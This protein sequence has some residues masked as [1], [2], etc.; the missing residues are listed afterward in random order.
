M[1]TISQDFS[2]STLYYSTFLT[3]VITHVSSYVDTAVTSVQTSY[4]PYTNSKIF[5][6]NNAEQPM[7]NTNNAAGGPTT[8]SSGLGG[9]ATVTYAQTM[10]VLYL[11][12]H[13]NKANRSNSN[14][15]D[16]FFLYRTAKI[17]LVP[18]VTE[19]NG[20]LACITTS[21]FYP[22]TF[23][24][25]IPGSVLFTGINSH[26]QEYYSSV[27]A[28]TNAT[29]AAEISLS[30]PFVLPLGSIPAEYT[31]LTLPTP[32]VS[33]FINTKRKMARAIPTSTSP[34]PAF[35]SSESEYGYVPNFFI[36]FL[37]QDPNY[38][39]QF[40]QLASCFPGGPSIDPGIKTSGL[41]PGPTLIGNLVSST[42]S[43]AHPSGCFDLNSPLCLTAAKAPSPS[44][45]P[46]AESAPPL[47]PNPPAPIVSPPAPS[48]NSPAAPSPP[49][50]PTYN[51]NSLS[52]EQL[53]NLLSVLQVPSSPPTSSPPPVRAPLQST[54]IQ[55]PP[56]SSPAPL[57]SP[58]PQLIPGSSSTQPPPPSPPTLIS[59]PVPQIIPA[60]S[61]T[62]PPAPNPPAPISSPVP[63]IIPASP[64]TQPPPPTSLQT[65]LSAPIVVSVPLSESAITMA[66]PAPTTSIAV[67]HGGASRHE[68]KPSWSLW[69]VWLGCFTLMIC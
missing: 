6:Y 16:P 49:A 67:F 45:T 64:S 12:Q 25:S 32:A 17:I 33:D 27:T 29:V 35:N 37:A 21:T 44:T 50:P 60:S 4:I 1:L 20:Q 2:T 19:S 51:P 48:P 31:S 61:S 55:P 68:G 10:Y 39:A 26:A 52:P 8:V 13:F 63:Q 3:S 40:P 11:P 69:S 36:S 41:V 14:S 43:V 23:D 62:Q 9:T 34:S 58:A 53:T 7:Q 66:E 54:A 56:Q 57:S 59:P 47:A 28:T 38:V 30:T 42:T 46:V 18:A 65:S 22:S 24:T 5:E 15:P